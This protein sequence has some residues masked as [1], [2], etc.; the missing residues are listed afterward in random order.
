[1][2]SPFTVNPNLSLQKDNEIIALFPIDVVKN[3]KVIN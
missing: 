3:F 1:M 2:L